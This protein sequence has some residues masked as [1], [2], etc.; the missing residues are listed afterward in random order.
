MHV[1][2]YIAN[3]EEIVYDCSGEIPSLQ[4]IDEIAL[5]YAKKRPDSLPDTIFINVRLYGPLMS[6][7]YPGTITFSPL[8]RKPTAIINTRAGPLAFKI[9]PMTADGKLFLIGQEDDFERYDIDNIFEKVVLK[10]CER[11]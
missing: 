3:G 4:D 9:L 2:Y 7:V 10:D 8:D 11:V 5:Q 6:S 1:Q